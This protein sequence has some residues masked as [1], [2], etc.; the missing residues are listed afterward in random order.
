M[1][2]TLQTVDISSTTYLPRLANVVLYIPPYANRLS[3]AALSANLKIILTKY[4]PTHEL[5]NRPLSL[6]IH[7]II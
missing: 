5:A 6:K 2:E 4:G 3:Y 1:M 7:F